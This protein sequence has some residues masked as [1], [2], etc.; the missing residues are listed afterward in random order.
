MYYIKTRRVVLLSQYPPFSV[1]LVIL[2][3]ST[4]R[5]VTLR[6]AAPFS[7]LLDLS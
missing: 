5:R 2:F 1:Y 3:E 4:V 6:Y 7:S